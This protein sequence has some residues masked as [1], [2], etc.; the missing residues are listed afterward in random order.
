[1]GADRLRPGA[2]LAATAA[3]LGLALR[4]WAGRLEVRHGSGDPAEQ[5]AVIG[6]LRERA[7]DV[8]AYCAAAGGSGW[9]L[10]PHPA[11]L[12]RAERALAPLAAGVEAW[13]GE[14]GCSLPVEERR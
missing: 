10:A 8:K 12:A 4:L 14:A 5:E 6:W 11:D 7:A 9:P 1:M 3:R 13:D 2:R